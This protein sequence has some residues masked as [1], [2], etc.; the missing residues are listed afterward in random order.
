MAAI[1]Q[2]DADKAASDALGRYQA[3]PTAAPPFAGE[4]ISPR[5][6]P[7]R[8]VFEEYGEKKLLMKAAFGT[9]HGSIPRAGVA[10]KNNGC[11]LK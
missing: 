5:R 2:A 6:N 1:K 10:R 4:V 7:A 11:E 8:D 3:E 9:H